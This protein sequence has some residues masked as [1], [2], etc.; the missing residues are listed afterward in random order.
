MIKILYEDNH[1][2]VVCKPVNMP[3]C[4]DASGDPDLLSLLKA[5]LKQR[6]Q[7]PGNVY[8]GLVHRLDRP[9]GGIMVFAKTSKAAARLSEQL[10]NQR[11]LKGYL[12]VVTG[13]TMDQATYIDKLYKDKNTNITTVDPRGKTAELSFETLAFSSELSL[14]KIRLNTG[15]SHQIRVQF[16][17]HGHPLWGDQKYNPQAVAKQQ[18]ALYANELAFQHPITK[19]RIE[20]NLKPDFPPFTLFG[21]Y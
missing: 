5:D 11:F 10:R 9:V 16:S 20:F 1:L 3:V 21:H 15:R 17:A 8:L 14:V 12:A 13:K 6:Y 18:L 7:K 4:P 2:L 19:E